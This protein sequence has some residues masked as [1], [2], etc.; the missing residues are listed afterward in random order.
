MVEIQDQENMLIPTSSSGL[1]F[2]RDLK[3]LTREV[4]EG[5]KVKCEVMGSPPATKFK[6]FRNKAPLREEAGRVKIKDWTKGTDTQWSI[7][8]FRELETL[9]TGFYICEASNSAT[10][11]K[12]EAVIKVNLGSG[13]AGKRGGGRLDLD[14]DYVHLLGTFKDP[15]ESMD[16]LTNGI[17]KLPAHFVYLGVLMVAKVRARFKVLCPILLQGIS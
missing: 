16:S 9:D 4:G 10:T 2:V 8:M 13:G 15:F 6:W 14:D 11:I 3:D 17:N 5:L 1:E 7:L 12:T